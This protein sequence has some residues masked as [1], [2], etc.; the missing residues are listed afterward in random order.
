MSINVIAAS[1]GIENERV[2]RVRRRDVRIETTGDKVVEHG[3]IVEPVVQ[4]PF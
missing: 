4:H 1:I 3:I 2:R